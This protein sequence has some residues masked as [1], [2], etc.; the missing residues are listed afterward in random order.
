VRS[1]TPDILEWDDLRELPGERRC[2]QGIYIQG[3]V[4]TAENCA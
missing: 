1:E 4:E 2:I 3:G